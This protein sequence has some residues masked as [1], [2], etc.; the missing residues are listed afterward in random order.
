MQKVVRFLLV[1]ALVLPTAVLASSEGHNDHDVDHDTK[2]LTPEEEAE[3]KA[4]REKAHR[5]HYVIHHTQDSHDFGLFSNESEGKHYGFPLPVILWDD[6]IHFFM[7][8]KFDHGHKVVESNGKYF[9][10]HY[11][12]GKVY[13]MNADGSPM[14][15]R[16]W[17]SETKKFENEYVEV[18]D[19]SITKNVLVTMLM[20]VLMFFLFRSI[21][22]SYKNGLAPT[23]AAK[24]FEPIII[25]V[26]DEIARPNIGEKH[27]KKYMVYLLTV[28]FFIWFLNLS[29]MTP[30]GINV[31]GNI[32]FTA[33]LALM[34]YLITTFTG[35]K[36]YWMHIFW[37]PGVPW[38][39]K[40]VLA[41][42]ELLGTI[43]KPFALMIRLYANMLAGHIVLGMLI[44]AAYGFSNYFASG[45]FIGLTFFMNI[46]ELLV[47]LLQAYIFTM[48]TALYFGAA[49]EE[50]DHEHAAA[51]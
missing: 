30:L 12:D 42:I 5:K 29:G 18:L 3:R 9:R 37:M 44:L 51:H 46:I 31:T 15:E 32:A 11:G 48:L 21:A 38:P 6:G 4:E 36:D 40:I 50:H 49:A 2:D 41:P 33:A 17:N 25:Y 7:S 47:A 23:G 22:R 16:V 10:L 14:T 26:R 39:M 28:F 1:L 43:I 35:K 24:F 45:A 27:Y 13:K 8:S 34:T 19:F 20:V